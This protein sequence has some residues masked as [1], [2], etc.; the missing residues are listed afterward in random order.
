MSS[1]GPML[2]APRNQAQPGRGIGCGTVF[3]I[4][5]LLISLVLNVIMC[6]GLLLPDVSSLANTDGLHLHEKFHSGNRTATDKIAIVRVEGTIMEGMLG[7]AHQQIDQAARDADVKAIVLLVNSPGGSITAS[8]DMLRRLEQ[9]RDGKN[10][11]Y[12]G[13]PKP[14]VVSMGS[15]C[16]S[17]GYYISMAAQQDAVHPKKLFADR[18][19]ITGSIG[20][21]ASLPNAKGLAE[22][23]GVTM[24]MIKAGDIKGSGSPFHELTPQERQ[25][26]QDMVENAYAQFI[27]VVETGRPALKGKLTVPL[28]AP[29]QIAKYDS[30]GN[31]IDK[32][33][34]EYVRKRADGGIYTA[35]QALEIGLIDAVGPIDDAI[36][37]VAKQ[38]SMGDWRAVT[39]EKPLSL[40]TALTG[41]EAKAPS[42][43]LPNADLWPRLW[44]L[45]PAAEVGARI[46]E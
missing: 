37:E 23:I 9:L 19:C 32:K 14:L 6:S 25:P 36:A 38:A 27:A 20:V 1:D 7:F 22:K 42:G 26:W 12:P 29:K 34:G 28:A 13:R 43:G 40:L 21:Y 46:R 33:G 24:E 2:P 39:F 35:T 41:V 16:A 11:R 5:V 31:V 30:K 15:L 8:D 3:L 18:S 17:G 10:P 44:F 45:L 4:F